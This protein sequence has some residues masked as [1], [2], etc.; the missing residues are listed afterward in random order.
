MLRT[1][2]MSQFRIFLLSFFILIVSDITWYWFW[3]WLGRLIVD[4]AKEKESVKE[5]IKLGKQINSDPKVRV[6]IKKVRDWFI[7]TFDWAT[8]EENEFLKYLRSGG[9][10]ALYFLSAAPI[11]G[12]RV[13][14]T[15]FCRPL[16]NK[17]LII[18][19]LGDTTKT[20][21]MIFG[22]WNLIFWLF[23]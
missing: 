6:Y 22:F 23:S 8:N 14:A 12:A 4:I 10:V 9:Y 7:Q 2:N 21:I 17:A 5:A 11:S 3:G 16:P 1:Q 15:I 18:L 19:I 13:V 20:A